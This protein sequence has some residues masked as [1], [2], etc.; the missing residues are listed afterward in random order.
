MYIIS[1][2]LFNN[3]SKLF[4]I[5]DDSSFQEVEKRENAPKQLVPT[6]VLEGHLGI[7][8]VFSPQSGTSIIFP[9]IF[10]DG[11]KKKAWVTAAKTNSWTLEVCQF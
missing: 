7:E 8:R 9:H 3:H 6:P 5:F 1:V 2:C 4:S 10:S 11:T